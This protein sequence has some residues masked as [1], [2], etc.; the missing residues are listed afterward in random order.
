MTWH[1]PIIELVD[2]RGEFVYNLEVDEDHS[3]VAG[4]IVVHNCDLLAAQNIHGLG[5]GVYPT[6]ELTPWPAHPNTL[7]F[8]VAVFEDEV[9]EADRA[10]KETPLQ[11][12]QRLGPEI[13]AGALGATKAEYFD[14]GL[15]TRGMLRAPLRSVEERLQRQ[16]KLS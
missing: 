15:L 6:R 8:L 11:A 5:P 3:Y 2:T 10:G 14:Q 16:G 1:Q 7:S 9:S 13:R 4:G 12:L